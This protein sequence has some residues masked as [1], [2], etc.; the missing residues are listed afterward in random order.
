MILP[1]KRINS[2]RSLLAIGGE[3]LKLL[4]RPKSISLLWDEFKNSKG[5]GSNSCYIT[6]DWFILS[7]DLLYLMQ[8]IKIDSGRIS[9]IL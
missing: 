4:N 5:D 7:L 2:G 6:Y 1:T 9:R 3:T 8:I